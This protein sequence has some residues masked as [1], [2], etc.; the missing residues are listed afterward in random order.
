MSLLGVGSTAFTGAALRL[1][2]RGIGLLDDIGLSLNLSLGLRL[3]FLACLRLL[4]LCLRALCLE[5]CRIEC[6]DSEVATVTLEIDTPTAEDVLVLAELEEMAALVHIGAERHG[7]GA[8]EHIR[9]LVRQVRLE[10]RHLHAV[11]VRDLGD[12]LL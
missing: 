8:G 7:D 9:D 5:Q 3:C 11:G 12:E 2:L 10:R 4:G 6:L 1:L